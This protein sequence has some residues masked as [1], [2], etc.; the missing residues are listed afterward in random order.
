ME[1]NYFLSKE[2]RTGIEPKEKYQET[3][4]KQERHQSAYL[5]IKNSAEKGG[6]RL[7]SLV[8]DVETA[9][10]RYQETILRFPTSTMG[11]LHLWIMS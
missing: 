7:S 1:R 3:A 4:Q 10:I 2:F 11:H 5:S 6:E 8:K 9:A